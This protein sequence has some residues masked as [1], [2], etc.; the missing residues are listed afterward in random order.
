MFETLTESQLLLRPRQN[1]KEILNKSKIPLQHVHV[2]L[3]QH[4]NTNIFNNNSNQMVVEIAPSF[5][6]FS[7]LN[8][9]LTPTEIEAFLFE[10]GIA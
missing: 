6:I 1:W 3:K 4:S 7:M 8:M 10:W 2:M 9:D 5:K